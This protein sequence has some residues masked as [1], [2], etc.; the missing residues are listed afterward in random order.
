[1]VRARELSAQFGVPVRV[2]HA[3]PDSRVYRWLLLEKATL[4]GSTDLRRTRELLTEI[5]SQPPNTRLQL[6][7]PSFYGGHPFVRTD[8]SRRSLSAL[9]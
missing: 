2:H 8:N 3:P 5:L 1:L 7:P 6:A 9:R 4:I